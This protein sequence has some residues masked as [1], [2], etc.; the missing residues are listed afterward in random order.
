[1]HVKSLMRSEL[2]WKLARLQSPRLAYL[3]SKLDLCWKTS[4][5]V[6]YVQSVT[7]QMTGI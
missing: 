4:Q 3:S 6:D 7:M 5:L 1:M 2:S